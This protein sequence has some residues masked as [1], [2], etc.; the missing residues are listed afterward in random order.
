MTTRSDAS[1]SPAVLI[2]GAGPA[3][4]GLAINCRRFG[5]SVRVVDRLATAETASKALALW[6]GSLETLS[7]MG[8]SGE[9]L[10]AGLTINRV[11]L[12]DGARTL[13][14]TVTGD[15][16][17]SA[18]SHPVMLPQA[19]TERLMTERLAELGVTVERGYTI[20]AL[21]QDAGG[22]TVR[23]AGPD[24]REE[25]VR[26]AYLA[27]CDGSASAVRGLL[28]IGVEHHDEPETYLIC[29]APLEGPEES[30]TLYMWWGG[31]GTLALCPI[32]PGL[33]RVIVR[34]TGD[35]AG[36]APPAVEEI[37][38]Q[39]AACGPKGFRL[40]EPVSLAAYR[41]SQ[42]LAERF[43][44]GR[45][46]LLGDAAH[47][48]S[49]VGGQGL[50][51]GLL[52]AANL[53]WKL[54]AMVRGQG[55]AEAL[56]A[57]YDAER[58]AV[59]R[60]VIESSL[61]RLNAGFAGGLLARTTRDVVVSALSRV[62]PLR[63]RMM[64]DFSDLNFAYR[65]GPLA[66]FRRLVSTGEP[67]VGE[68]A[69]NA[70]YHPGGSPQAEPLWNAFSAP[71]HILLRFGNPEVARPLMMALTEFGPAVRII[72]IDAASDPDGEVRRRYSMTG[73]GFVLLRPDQTVALRGAPLDV[74]ILDA[75]AR[76][77]LRSGRRDDAEKTA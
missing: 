51:M 44:A 34:R 14:D 20:S 57:S 21:A 11:K 45:C 4:L 15:G 30:D 76:L 66:D 38:A 69:P 60:S 59:A 31:G 18:F 9:V 10:A 8:L 39:L 43:R 52:D 32:R 42:Q 35:N 50:N 63:R 53:G 23:L 19:E 12:G 6:S 41:I 17:D 24:G 55:D 56:A 7:V 48:H 36:D 5:I 1:A 37:R 54:A 25:D 47:T 33:W 40:G 26:T 68:R 3:G 65:D 62:A 29:D 64:A 58:R 73:D 67:T 74:G 49:P 27:G 77:A 22:V 46:F 70:A 2:I 28:G 75:Y 72:P 61:L 13:V 71:A 16:S